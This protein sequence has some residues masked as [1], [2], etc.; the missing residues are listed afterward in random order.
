MNDHL[1]SLFGLDGRTAIVTG[2]SSGIGLGIATALAR[3][4]TATV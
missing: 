3:A 4:G 1:Q 2:G